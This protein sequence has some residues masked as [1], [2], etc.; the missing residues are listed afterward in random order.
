MTAAQKPLIIIV[1]AP[2]L[3]DHD[4]RPTAVVHA[5][6][7]A[8]PGLCLGWTTSEKE[9]LI[10]L[11]H[12]D[13]WVAAKLISGGFPFLCN[14]DDYHLVTIAGLENPNGLA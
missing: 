1:H 2:A 6:E 4:D 13:E 12:R 7:R 11:P 3:V 14:D 8:L 10:A 5:M 9:D